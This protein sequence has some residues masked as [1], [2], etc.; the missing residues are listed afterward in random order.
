M[1][2]KSEMQ[3]EEMFAQA[4]LRML[5]VSPRKLNDVASLVRKMKVAEALM[6]LEFCRKRISQDVKKCLMSAVANAENNHNMDIDKLY[7]RDIL[8]GKAIVMKRFM[9]RA[10]GRAG[11]IR[12]MLSNITITLTEIQE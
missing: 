12:K 2:S 8:V 1:V 5:R 11:K 7:I 9:P 10:R 3:N 6:Q 4:K